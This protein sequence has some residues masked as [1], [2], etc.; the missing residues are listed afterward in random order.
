MGLPSGTRLGPYE[1]A[2][3]IGA[4]GMGEVYKA[5]DTR[6]DR[7]VAIKV[8]TTRHEAAP[9]DR[10]RFARE[11]RAISALNHPNICSLYDIGSENGN[12]F[13]VMEYIEGETLA[14]RLGR[15][16]LTPAE[17]IQ[18]G[19]EIAS[20]LERAHRQGIVHR[21]LKP[22]NIMLTRTGA[23][24]LDF[25]LARILES[26][27]QSASLLTV[28]DA[29]VGTIEYMAPEQLNGGTVDAR[30]DI[31]SLG[32]VL[33]EMI[34]G[35][36]PF[37]G[38][39]RASVIGAILFSTPSAITVHD[40]TVPAALERL[41]TACLAKDPN[42]RVQT[43]H[44]VRLNLEWMRDGASGQVLLPKRQRRT[45]RIWLFAAAAVTVAGLVAAA[46]V[47]SKLVSTQRRSEIRFTL[48]APV[49]GEQIDWPIISPDGTKIAFVS[50]AAT[51]GGSLWIR[52]LDSTTAT[53]LAGTDGATQPFWS[54]D[55]SAIA[56]FAGN[57]LQMLPLGSAR[58]NTLAMAAG[59]RGGTWSRNGTLLF[60]PHI[61]GAIWATSAAGAP[62]REVTRLDAKQG[63]TSHRWPEFLP[64]GEHFI[65]VIRSSQLQRAGLYV[66]SLRDPTIRKVSTLQSRAL[67]TRDG[68]ML[69]VDGRLLWR[70]RFD[71]DSHVLVG[72]RAA[73]AENIE[74]DLKITGAVRITAADDGTLAFLSPADARTR[75]N[76]V[77]DQGKVI[78]VLTEPGYYV[79]PSLSP[80][81]KTLAISRIDPDTGRNAIWLIDTTTGALSPFVNDG[82]N[83]DSPIW[84]FDGKS[85]LYTSDR[86]GVFETYVRG[87]DA[88]GGD[89][90]VLA[91]HKFS[92]PARDT[93]AGTL[94]Y[95][96]DGQNSG[97]L[98]YQPRN[99]TRAR[100]LSLAEGTWG[101]DLSPD[102]R[103]LI[104]LR[105]SNTDATYDI[106]LQA[107]DDPARR[108]QITPAAGAQALWRSDGRGFFYAERDGDLIA[109]EFD[110]GRIGARRRLFTLSN[111]D[112]FYSTTEYYPSSDGK[113]FITLQRVSNASTTAVVI[114]P[115]SK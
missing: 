75:V 21:D 54:P 24:L 96:T 79:N 64:D 32:V 55:G 17:T 94:I 83:A 12:E 7:P 50:G 114:V 84:S 72:E 67:V 45:R 87:I 26:E 99:G 110:D 73:V 25:G 27:P 40:R 77:D 107:V 3:R 29:I 39:N 108:L 2:A 68:W 42:D 82:V 80:D 58:P 81:D 28:E 66:G 63:D 49:A 89:R 69:F 6:L 109:T 48:G 34:S 51:R 41:I 88:V 106:Y 76:W 56:F 4:G 95:T 98:W 31:F 102:G 33:Y 22:G 103:W 11:A 46:V 71:L 18:Y 23:K 16:P 9:S 47:G 36:R 15:G 8:L 35:V 115:R 105:L 93:A 1:I 111:N 59:P 14:E 97:A 52:R 38:H 100:S 91:G 20:A 65:F 61:T 113:R 86:R 60:A 37:L 10:K 44:D 70:Q 13:L 101:G 43:A 85:I 57:K 74:P 19:W 78:H 104:G 62:S 5:V 30:A 92:Y 90:L 53:R 112:I